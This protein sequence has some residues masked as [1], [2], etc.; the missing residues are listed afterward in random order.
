MATTKI[1]NN[2]QIKFW[3]DSNLKRWMAGRGRKKLGWGEGVKMR[4]KEST[5]SSKY[6]IKCRNKSLHSTL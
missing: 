3:K 2:P 4:E 5:V 1:K 6:K